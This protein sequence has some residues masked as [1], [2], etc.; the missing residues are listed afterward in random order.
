MQNELGVTRAPCEFKKNNCSCEIEPVANSLEIAEVPTSKE[1][2]PALVVG[3]R[4]VVNT[5]HT[6]F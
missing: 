1:I 4:T 3:G 6:I 5:L 2:I